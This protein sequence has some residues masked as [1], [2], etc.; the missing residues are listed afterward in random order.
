MSIAGHVSRQVL[1]H[2][3]HIRLAAKRTALDSIATPLPAP[4]SENTP[5]FRGDVHQYGN[6]IGMPQNGATSRLLN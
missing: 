4:A 3:W 2:Y 1:E 5:V 6:Q